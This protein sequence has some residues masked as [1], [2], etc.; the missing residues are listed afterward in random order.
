MLFKRCGGMRIEDPALDATSFSKNRHLLVAHEVASQSF[1]ALVD[2][3]KER[4]L[5]W[6]ERLTVD[7]TLLRTS[8]SLNRLRRTILRAPGRGSDRRNPD[9]HFH[10]QRRRSDAHYSTTDSDARLMVKGSPQRAEPCFNGNVLMDKRNGLLLDVSALRATGLAE[11][12][13]A[14]HMLN[15]SRA[16]AARRRWTVARGREDDGKTFV[17]DSNREGQRHG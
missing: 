10:R 14:L 9:V 4:R 12:E 13:A 8:P 1:H 16:N 6:A 15:R 7:G 3:A 17:D 11:R 2:Q 5:I